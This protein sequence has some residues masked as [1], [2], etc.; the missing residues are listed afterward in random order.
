MISYAL[1]IKMLN[2]W[3]IT[4]ITLSRWS[5]DVEMNMSLLDKDR[6]DNICIH[7]QLGYKKHMLVKWGEWFRINC[8]GSCRWNLEKLC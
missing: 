7:E 5:D 1:W 3:Q 4:C 2:S 8:R 6:V